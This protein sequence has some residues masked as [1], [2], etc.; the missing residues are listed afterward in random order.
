LMMS[1]LT[2]TLA[3]AASGRSTRIQA[4]VVAHQRR[5]PDV[6]V[7]TLRPAA[8][9][10][11][12]PGQS[13]PIALDGRPRAWR[14]FTPAHAPREDGTLELHV[15]AV[16]GGYV[17]PALVFETA[18][19]DVV[20]VAEPVGTL[21]WRDPVRD[22]VLIASGTGIAPF[23]AMLE[24]RDRGR[25]RT[26]R[27]RVT[28]VNCARSEAGLYDLE[29]VRRLESTCTGLTVET[30]TGPAAPLWQAPGGPPAAADWVPQDWQDRDVF[31]CGSP[32]FAE[33]AV[34][35]L[36]AAGYDPSAVHV[37]QFGSSSPAP[38]GATAHG[39]GTA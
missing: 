39:G 38:R 37:E 13:L 27:H 4:E 20:A 25:G 34:A 16:A 14:P 6:A 1:P 31:V 30:R 36:L 26:S 35:S 22:A 5:G 11:F 12:V 2:G 9:V 32:A 8:R 7:L 10:D 18:P 33:A 23:A 24:G 29:S 21:G 28:L 15:R 19:G 17:S 3:A